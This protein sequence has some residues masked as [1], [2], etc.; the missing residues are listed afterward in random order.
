MTQQGPLFRVTQGQ[1]QG[2]SRVALLEAL[3]VSLLPTAFRPLAKFSSLPCP[4]WLS[5]VIFSLLEAAHSPLPPPHFPCDLL[6]QRWVKTTHTLNLSDSFFCYISFTPARERPLLLRVHVVQ[7]TI[8]DALLTIRSIPFV[9]S[10]K[11]LFCH[12]NDE[13]SGFGDKSIGNIWGVLKTTEDI[14]GPFPK[15]H[16]VTSATHPFLQPNPL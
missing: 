15:Y 13:F 3:M 10:A 8:Q 2:V 7:M 9:T 11:S 16:K 5:A 12:V 6:W 4:C 1:N 14:R